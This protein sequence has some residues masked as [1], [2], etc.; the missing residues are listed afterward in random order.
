MMEVTKEALMVTENLAN[1]LKDK[2]AELEVRIS[3]IEA[4]FKKGRSADFSEQT[5]E[6]END[7]VL[8]EIHHEAK[9]E[10]ML[11][12][13]AIQRIAQG[14]YGTCSGCEEKINPDRLTAL[15]YITT[16]INCAQ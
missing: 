3:A 8:D 9:A 16:C 15:P 12:N 13:N 7:E 14:N 2:R 11:V 10:L 5:T 4:D 6:S 1:I